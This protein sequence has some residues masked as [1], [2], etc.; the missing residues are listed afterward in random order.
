MSAIKPSRSYDPNGL[1]KIKARV[2][3]YLLQKA[4]GF[5]SF[6]DLTETLRDF[7][8]VIFLQMSTY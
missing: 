8:S 6:E 4:R 5:V 3:S 1:K 7:G 2:F